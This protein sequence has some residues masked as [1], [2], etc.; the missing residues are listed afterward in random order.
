MGMR[1][2]LDDAIFQPLVS[3]SLSIGKQINRVRGRQMLIIAGGRIILFVCLITIWQLVS[4][5]LVDPL[6]ISSPLAVMQQLLAWINDGTLWFHTVITLQEIMLGLLFGVSSGILAGFLLG[7]QPLLAK[8]LEPFLNALNSIPKVVLAPLFILWFGIDIQMK[9]VLVAVIV[10]FLV[11]FNTLAGV[12]DVDQSLVNAVLLMGGKRRD[13]LFKVIVPAAMG[14]MLTGLRIAVPYALIGAVIG[15][16]IASNRGIGYLVD[17][18]ATAFN[19]AGVFA[20]LLVLTIIAG[21]LNAVVNFID[22]KTSRW[23]AGVSIGRKV[24]R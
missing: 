14:S 1:T 22:Q 16:L 20:A 17:A 21:I 23:K 11:F 8:I 24:L 2:I 10:F 19:T 3:R 7:L 5:R 4:G 9:V 13:V 15:E 18:S 6:F 12:C